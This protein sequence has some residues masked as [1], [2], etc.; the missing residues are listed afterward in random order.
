MS[1]EKTDPLKSSGSSM[2]WEEWLG[3]LS[4]SA[5]KAQKGP[6]RPKI[7]DEPELFHLLYLQEFSGA[8][9]SI[10]TFA[11]PALLAERIREIR[12]QAGPDDRLFVF[13]G[14]RVHITVPPEP[15]LLIPGQA[16]IPLFDRPDVLEIAEEG[17]LGPDWEMPPP[18]EARREEEDDYEYANYYED[19]EENEPPPGSPRILDEEP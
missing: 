16:P 7:P 17:F 18:E 11:S 10:E 5:R 4:R 9:P 2:T 3:R 12:E 14:R 1:S 6:S 13:L 8:P 15:Y 19:E